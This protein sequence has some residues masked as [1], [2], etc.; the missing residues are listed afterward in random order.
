[1][2][3]NVTGLMK[4]LN[5]FINQAI[6]E[7][8]DVAT[9]MAALK[10]N[11]MRPVFTVDVSL[12]QAPGADP[13]EALGRGEELVLSDADVE[14]LTAVGISDPSWCCPTPDAPPGSS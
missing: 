1:M 6:L 3:K 8:D 11:G 12:Q 10:R 4:A 9:A 2:T 7:S 14:F 5:Q 13:V